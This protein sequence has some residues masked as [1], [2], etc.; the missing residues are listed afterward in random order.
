MLS[1][2]VGM[3]GSKMAGAAVLRGGS[4]GSAVAPVTAQQPSSRQIAH[5]KKVFH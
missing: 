4:A 1:G 3:A 2:M 5:R